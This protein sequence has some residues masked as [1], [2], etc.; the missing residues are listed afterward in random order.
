M[1]GMTKIV[2]EHTPAEV[3]SAV[4]QHADSPR[5]LPYD[6]DPGVMGVEVTP[7]ATGG[8]RVEIKLTVT[9]AG[10][11]LPTKLED[12]RRENAGWQKPRT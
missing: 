7:L 4:R 8:H 3:Y 2:H 1:R 11:D 9:F 6:F 12:E 10:T 5:W